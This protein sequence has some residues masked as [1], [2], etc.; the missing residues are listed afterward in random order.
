MLS[1][2]RTEVKQSR[3]RRAFA[4]L[5]KINTCLRGKRKTQLCGYTG[6]T[7][8][9]NLAMREA[10]QRDIDDTVAEMLAEEASKDVVR[11]LS[12]EGKCLRE[13]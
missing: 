10:F 12:L 7:T 11:K 4:P 3:P 6:N 2:S 9:E 13:V 5:N 8:E 1:V